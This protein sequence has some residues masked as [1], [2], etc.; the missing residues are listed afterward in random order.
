MSS[1]AGKG[2]VAALK[3]L[4]SNENVQQALSDLGKD[5]ELSGEL[6]EKLELFTCQLY[7]PKQPTTGVNELRH[8][9]F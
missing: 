5:W 1:F 4:K 6:F 9:L 7:V 2:K 3:I 8:Q